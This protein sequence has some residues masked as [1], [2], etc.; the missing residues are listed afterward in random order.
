M[1]HHGVYCDNSL[2]TALRVVFDASAPSTTE[3]ALNNL[4]MV[5]PTIQN[6]LFS[7]LI[8]FRQHNFV[9][10]ADVEKMYR[11]VL[12]AEQ[13]RPLQRILF[14]F[15]VS[16]PLEI[17]EVRSRMGQLPRHFSSY[18]AYFNYDLSNSIS[19]NPKKLYN[20]SPPLLDNIINA[21]LLYIPTFIS[22]HNNIIE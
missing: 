2:S 4:Q 8:G 21:A 5:C 11:C 10:A 14:R 22:E 17:Y 3:Y 1:R 13:N 18:F 7:I 9:I 19:E 12:F 15:D 6:N 20:V 16:Q